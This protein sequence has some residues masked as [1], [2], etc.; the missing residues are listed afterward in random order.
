MLH[1]DLLMTLTRGFALRCAEGF[2]GFLS[3]SVD[4]HRILRGVQRSKFGS[5]KF[6][7]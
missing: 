7:V 1:I 5:T 2:L 3:K 4:V 6:F